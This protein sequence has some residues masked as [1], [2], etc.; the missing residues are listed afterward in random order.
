MH[1][2]GCRGTG[3]RAPAAQ[4]P[5]LA[6]PK[7]CYGFLGTNTY[8]FMHDGFSAFTLEWLCWAVQ[9]LCV[10]PLSWEGIGGVGIREL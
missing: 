4:D 9:S 3:G 6:V 1:W 8:D 2:D 7:R 10:F 5:G